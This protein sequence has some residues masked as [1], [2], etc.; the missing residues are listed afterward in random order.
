M[1]LGLLLPVVV[2]ITLHLLSP[3]PTSPNP[4]ILTLPE[5]L[6][7]TLT[8]EPAAVHLTI[9]TRHLHILPLILTTQPQLQLH[10]ATDPHLETAMVQASH[11]RI[12]LLRLIHQLL[13]HR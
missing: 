4:T 8:Q 12:Q 3:F 13:P 5:A 10:P 2:V 7:L 1:D 9:Q 6:H 11:L